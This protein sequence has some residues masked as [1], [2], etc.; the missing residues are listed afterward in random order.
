LKRP[1]LTWDFSIAFNARW[2][3]GASRCASRVGSIPLPA[4]SNSASFNCPLSRLRAFDTAGGPI[5]PYLAARIHQNLILDGR[6]AWGQSYNNV[7]PL[8]LYEDDFNTNRWLVRGQVTGDFSWGNW[9][10]NPSVGIS[11]FSET[12]K[13]YVDSLNITIP[14]QTITLGRA[15]AGPEV[16]YN[17]QT[18]DGWQFAPHVGVK[19]IWDFDP[20]NIVTAQGV[21]ID[22]SGLRARAEG[23]TVFIMPWG[24]SLNG[25]G[26]YDGIGAKDFQ[27]YGGSVRVR[28]PLN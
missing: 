16:R 10:F 19:G 20:A 23:G 28:V 13:S 25:T 22:S 21:T 27:S 6:A 12:Q 1:E 24:W 18:K 3:I 14:S 4:R 8:G 15:E 2:M 5:G 26:F 7:N 11:Y 9:T 17:L